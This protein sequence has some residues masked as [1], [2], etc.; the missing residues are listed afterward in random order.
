MPIGFILLLPLLFVAGMSLVDT[1]DG[2]AMLG[3]YSWAFLRPIRKLYYNFAL[4]SVSV[5]VAL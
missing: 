5:A 4:T 2:V 3:A 1:T